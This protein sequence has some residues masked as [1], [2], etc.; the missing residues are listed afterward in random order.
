MRIALLGYGK[1]GKAIET[2]ALERG[3]SIVAKINS[4]LPLDQV[5]WSEVDI[6]IEFTRPELAPQHIAYCAT[7]PNC[8]WYYRMASR[9][10]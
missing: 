5:N 4:Q 9:L 6:C 2:S 10:T 3:H 8:S 1:M 7:S